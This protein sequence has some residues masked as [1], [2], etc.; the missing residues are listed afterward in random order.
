MDYQFGPNGTLTLSDDL[1]QVT[2]KFGPV[3]KL[4]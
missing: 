2:L 3:V 4:E 1:Y